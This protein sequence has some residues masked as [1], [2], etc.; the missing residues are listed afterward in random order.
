MKEGE[1][2]IVTPPIAESDIDTDLVNLTEYL[3]KSGAVGDQTGG[4]GLGGE[5]GYG[6]DF[7]NDVF[8]MHHFCWCEKDDCD[9]CNR[10]KPN[11]LYKPNGFEVTWYKWIGRDTHYSQDLDGNAWKRIFDECVASIG[12]QS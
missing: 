5:F 6:V 2:I 8:M 1:I 12:K 10:S 3:V 4:Y 11:F 9:W 7:E